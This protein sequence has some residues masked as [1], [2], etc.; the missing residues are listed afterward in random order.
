[1][2]N[3]LILDSDTTVHIRWL[4]WVE[5]GG[6]PTR[7][8]QYIRA[9]GPSTRRRRSQLLHPHPHQG[10]G[11]LKQRAFSVRLV[12]FLSLDLLSGHVC[13]LKRERPVCKK[14]EKGPL[15]KTSQVSGV[16]S[17]LIWNTCNWIL[18]KKER[19]PFLP[20]CRAPS[21][22][23]GVRGESDG[24]GCLIR[25]VQVWG[26]GPQASFMWWCP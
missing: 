24:P 16:K 3:A 15:S 19:Q 11:F 7:A 8:H 4:W 23:W 22:L 14:T 21:A 20:L 18:C 2:T 17:A 9:W 26:S 10:L 5:R 1:M 6:R 25:R 13:V 12:V